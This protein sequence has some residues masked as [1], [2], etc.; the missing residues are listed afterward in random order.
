METQYIGVDRHKATFHACALRA[1]GTRLWE[2]QFPRTAEG[3][4]AFAGR[5][6]AQAHVAVEATGPTWA[7]VDAVHALGAPVCV[8]DTRQTKLK[9]GFAAKTDRLDARRLADALRR[10]SVVSLY[11]PSPAIRELREWCRGRQH[12][13]RTR[14]KLVQMIRARLVR[15]DVADPP[16]RQLA[17][18]RGLAW[19]ETVTRTGSAGETLQ[20]Y[21]R[22]W[23]AIHAECLAAHQR[24]VAVAA[25]DPIAVALTTVVGVG[26]VLSLTLRAEIGRIERFTH[27]RY[28]ASD[29]G[30]VP[31]VDA[32]ANRVRYGAITREGSPW[33]RWALV[34][35]AVHGLKRR[36]A[37]GR[38]ARRLAVRKSVKKAR[39]ALARRLCDEIVRVWTRLG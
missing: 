14:T 17:T 5:G 22:V 31:D 2:A 35:A 10:E 32:S 30:L 7:F 8:V 20:R 18:P 25:A 36:D 38:W 39:V 6:V 9:A 12:L 11:I 27:G 15:Q 37:I 29:A 13:V 33:L 23:R 24:V 3:L 16:R 26:P 19:L 1:D 28:L 34:E 4:A 21:T